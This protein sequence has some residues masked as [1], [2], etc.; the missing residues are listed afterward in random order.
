MPSMAYR[1]TYELLCARWQVG[2]Q[3]LPK[4]L[5]DPGEALYLEQLIE[6]RLGLID[7]GLTRY[8]GTGC[9]L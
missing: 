4:S 1:P 9:T 6:T 3:A 8:Q 7:Q 5:T 2:D